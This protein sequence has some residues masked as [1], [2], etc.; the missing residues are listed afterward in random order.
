MMKLP[1]LPTASSAQVRGVLNIRDGSLQT[2]RLGMV[3]VP[4]Q[5]G[6]RVFSTCIYGPCMGKTACPKTE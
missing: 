5:A 2:L 3:V 1:H 6:P 4:V